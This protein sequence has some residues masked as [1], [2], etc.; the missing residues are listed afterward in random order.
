MQANSD[1][2]F[3]PVLC[4]VRLGSLEDALDLI[5]RSGYGNGAAIFTVDGGA[6]RRFETE[7]AAG[8]IGINV[9][10]PVSVSY[11]SIGGWNSL[12]FGNLHV[13]RPDGV[14]FYTRGKA[15]TSRWQNIGRY[16]TSLFSPAQ[17]LARR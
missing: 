11:Y 5:E 8:M 3:E 14:R 4:L 2:I 16:R 7:V 10:V 15:V 13:Y 9:A 1:E 17:S 6:T 12:L